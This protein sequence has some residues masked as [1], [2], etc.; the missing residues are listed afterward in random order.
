MRKKKR[1]NFW[2]ALASIHRYMRV[3]SKATSGTR[4]R[5]EQVQ[6]WWFKVGLTRRTTKVSNKVTTT[7]KKKKKKKKRERER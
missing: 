5:K 3:S 7:K 6:T 1:T 2:R 4:E